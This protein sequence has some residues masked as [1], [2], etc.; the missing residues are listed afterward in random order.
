MERTLSCAE[1][2][3]LLADWIDGTLAVPL[4]SGRL[5]APSRILQGVRGTGGRRPLRPWLYGA[6]GRCGNSTRSGDEDPA[7]HEFRLGIQAARQGHQRLDQPDVR[8]GIAATLRDGR[9]ADADVADHHGARL[10]LARADFHGGRPR[11]RAAV[12]FARQPDAS[13]LGSRGEEL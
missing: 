11:P 6:R 5:R 2:E 10:R 4:S 3:I 1:F 9:G 13:H 12:D 7:C 8:A